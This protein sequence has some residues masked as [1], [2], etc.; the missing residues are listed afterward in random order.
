MAKARTLGRDDLA[1]DIRQRI[2]FYRSG[3]TGSSRRTPAA[4]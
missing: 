3:A 1:R 4:P 2:A